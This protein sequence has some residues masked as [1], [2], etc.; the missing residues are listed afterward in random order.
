MELFNTLI[1]V[2]LIA[3]TTICVYV[4]FKNIVLPVLWGLFVIIVVA[5]TCLAY[6]ICKLYD[7]I[8]KKIKYKL[9]KKQR[10]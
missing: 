4:V 8:K 7:L 1:L 6:S 10:N 9:R 3:I 5:F 2:L